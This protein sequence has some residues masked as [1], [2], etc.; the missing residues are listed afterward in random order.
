M[1]SMI[2]KMLFYPVLVLKYLNDFII[3]TFTKNSR[4][5]LILDKAIHYLNEM[6]IN[7]S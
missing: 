6:K 7:A 1:Y 2:E 5:L 3:I 4:N